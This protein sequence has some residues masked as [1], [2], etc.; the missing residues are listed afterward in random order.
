M[1]TIV[2]IAYLSRRAKRLETKAFFVDGANTQFPANPELFSIPRE[3]GG[4][5]FKGR[6]IRP[7]CRRN[8]FTTVRYQDVRIVHGWAWISRVHNEVERRSRGKRGRRRRN[9]C[10]NQS[11][12]GG[13]GERR[14]VK[15][16]GEGGGGEEGPTA[17]CSWGAIRI[18]RGLRHPRLLFS[19]W[20]SSGKAL[21]GNAAAE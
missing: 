3:R 18:R 10:R 15:E 5:G 12:E 21:H 17:R 9:R 14:K 20:V 19:V 13:V 6:G 4:S 11:K 2:H 16:R 8:R 1:V 7:R